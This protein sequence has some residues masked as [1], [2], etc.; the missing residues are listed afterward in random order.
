MLTDQEIQALIVS[1]DTAIET[2]NRMKSVIAN[3]SEKRKVVKK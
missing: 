1:I 2:C 3:V